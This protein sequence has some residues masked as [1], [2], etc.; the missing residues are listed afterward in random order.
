V[1]STAGLA[2]E[3]KLLSKPLKELAVVGRR[4]EH[5]A[6]VGADTKPCRPSW[7]PTRTRWLELI[8]HD[9]SSTCWS[10]SRSKRGYQRR[11]T[12]DAARR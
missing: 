10:S 9:Q 12:C 11:P 1:C 7:L 2:P 8:T 3:D 5:I 4:Y 6:I